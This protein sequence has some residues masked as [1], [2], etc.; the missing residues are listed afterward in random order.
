MVYSTY[1]GGKYLF[2]IANTGRKMVAANKLSDLIDQ[3][4]AREGTRIS[5]EA[6][7]I[8]IAADAQRVGGQTYS[9]STFFCWCS[10]SAKQAAS[11]AG[12]EP[13]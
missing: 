1:L 12:C 10:Y 7:R 2:T 5:P 6:A 11:D 13:R 8:L 4:E 3:V 9:P